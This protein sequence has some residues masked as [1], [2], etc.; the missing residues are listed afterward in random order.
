V[1]PLAQQQRTDRAHKLR[2]VL[3]L[4]DDGALLELAQ[5]WEN[6]LWLANALLDLLDEGHVALIAAA[7]SHV[8]P[9]QSTEAREAA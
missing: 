5:S 9:W 3:Q 2:R 6:P 4:G 7:R 8:R 1:N